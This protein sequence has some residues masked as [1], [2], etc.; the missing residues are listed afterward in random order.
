MHS[1]LIEELLEIL[2]I[3]SFTGEEQ[4][5]CDHVEARI[6]QRFRDAAIQPTVE[7]INNSLIVRSP[8]RAGAP[9]IGLAG[10]LDT[11]KGDE[12]GPRVHVDAGRIVGLGA[13]DMKAGVAVMLDLLSPET[14]ESLSTN[15]TWIF[16]ESEEGSYRS[17]GLHEIFK[18]VPHLQEL[19]LCFILEPTD[20]T[21]HLGCMG[22]SHARVLF[23]G[24]RAHSARP[25][26][27]ENAIHKSAGFLARL[28]SL[29]P[30]V[31]SIEGLEFKEVISAT[32]AHSGD[33]SSNVVPD[34]FELSVNT[35]FS[36]N[37]TMEA[38]R[39]WLS[40]LVQG[41]ASVEFIDE[42]PSCPVPS[43][44]PILQRFRTRFGLPVHPKLAYTD[45]ALFG[46]HGIPAVNCGPGL[47][48]QAHQRGEF[49]L[50]DDV[51]RS[52]ELYRSFLCEPG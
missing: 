16:Y 26:Q 19:E 31:V 50:L 36:P 42:S 35:R 5:I 9:T 28:A 24:R 4:R 18:R 8:R 10:H 48:A 27:G 46:L 43:G 41:E 6:A 15:V 49:V 3:E 40:D 1:A 47:T 7:R 21:L 34:R 17:N 11:V 29:S 45:V 33:N 12:T 44:N 51:V 14:I 37:T 13:S 32:V 23:E 38:A 30:R 52:Y 2:R 25:W 22:T 39:Q 20:S